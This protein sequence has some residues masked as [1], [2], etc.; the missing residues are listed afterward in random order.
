MPG[1]SVTI[2]T[3]GIL[4]IQESNFGELEERE[5]V[6]VATVHATYTDTFG[7]VSPSRLT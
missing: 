1:S 2:V 5:Y 6:V 7:N 3:L 4:C